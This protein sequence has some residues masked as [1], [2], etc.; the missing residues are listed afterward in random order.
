MSM[1]DAGVVVT[2]PMGRC[3]SSV[4]RV[5]AFSP[6][7]NPWTTSKYSACKQFFLPLQL[8]KKIKI[9]FYSVSLSRKFAHQEFWNF[10]I[11]SLLSST[12]VF[13]VLV[14]SYYNRFCVFWDDLFICLE[15]KIYF[16]LRKL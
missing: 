10:R 1:S 16:L 14:C 11:H 5:G 6:L 2:W 3:F 8:E 13:V 4:T 12:S 9:P 7:I 15:F